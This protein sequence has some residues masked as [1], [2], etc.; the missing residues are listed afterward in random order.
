MRSRASVPG[1][2]WGDASDPADESLARHLC[3]SPSR[4]VRLVRDVAHSHSPGYSQPSRKVLGRSASSRC[5]PQRKESDIV[6]LFPLLPREGV[7]LLQ[8]VVPQRSLFAVLGNKPPKPRKAK[9]LTFG[10][11]G[12]YQP[13]AVKKGCLASVQEYLLLLVAH[14]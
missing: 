2:L 11:V 10:V 14:A 3:G 1:W 12:L 7:K 9:H 13:V 5:T 6:L 8:E 4:R